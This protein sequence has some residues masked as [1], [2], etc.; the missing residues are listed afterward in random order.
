MVLHRI[1]QF[2]SLIFQPLFI[3][4]YAFYLYVQI[5]HPSV[6]VFQTQIGKPAYNYVFLVLLTL[7]VLIPLASMM[8]MLRSGI[9]SSLKLPDRKERLPVIFLLFFYYGLTYFILRSANNVNSHFIGPFMYFLFSGVIISLFTFIITLKWKISI[10]AIAIGA[11]SGGFLALT[12]LFY[13]FFNFDEISYINSLLLLL[14]GIVGSARLIEKVHQPM[15]VFAGLG[16]GFIT[17]FIIV[18]N[19]WGI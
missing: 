15:Q 7:A 4:V 2:I 18:I 10:H 13:P 11:F 12:S 14:M 19:Q 8:V 1:A 17:S 9:I 3:P 6:L 16:L 5:K